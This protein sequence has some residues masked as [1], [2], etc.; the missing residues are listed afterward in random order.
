MI[1]VYGAC[2]ALIIVFYS[3]S[4][5]QGSTFAEHATLSNSGANLLIGLMAGIA[6]IIGI[7]REVYDRRANAE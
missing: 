6:A 5:A 4:L 3:V 7:I 2:A 1:I